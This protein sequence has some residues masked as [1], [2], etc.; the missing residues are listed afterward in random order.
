[1]DDSYVNIDDRIT[2]N[3][4]PETVQDVGVLGEELKPSRNKVSDIIAKGKQSNESNKKAKEMFDYRR[5]QRK[6]QDYVKALGAKKILGNIPV[7]KPDKTSWVRVY[8]DVEMPVWVFEDKSSREFYLVDPDFC[9]DL[10]KSLTPATLYLAK[11]SRDDLFFWLVKTGGVGRGNR[12]TESSFQAVGMAK[13]QW[14]R[15]ESNMADGAY[16]VF[17]PATEPPDVEWGEIDI[18]K[19]L[20]EAFRGR[21]IDDPDHPILLNLKG[22]F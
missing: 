19:L 8:P 5:Y 6:P 22:R 11:T 9:A 17:V 3:A 21:I 4:V 7:K 14:V 18:D 2:A 12:W 15:V 13:N 1:M 16:D 20:E 10:G